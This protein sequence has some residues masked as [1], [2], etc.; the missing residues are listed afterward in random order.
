[1]S[2]STIRTHGN[3]M[4]SLTVDDVEGYFKSTI[5]NMFHHIKHIYP[6]PNYDENCVYSGQG[7]H[8]PMKSKL[9][10]SVP[11]GNYGSP[12]IRPSGNPNALEMIN[13]KITQYCERLNS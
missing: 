13:D 11:A 3:I 12:G 8:H 6:N 9:V 4:S 7:N 5:H 1:M 10:G 2:N